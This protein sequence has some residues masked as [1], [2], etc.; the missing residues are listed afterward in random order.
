VAV[1]RVGSLRSLERRQ[2]LEREKEREEE[3]QVLYRGTSP[4]GKRENMY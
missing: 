1:A 4:T 2:D 3:D